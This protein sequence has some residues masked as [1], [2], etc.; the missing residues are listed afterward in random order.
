M[1]DTYL[2]EEKYRELYD[3]YLRGLGTQEFANQNEAADWVRH[4]PASCFFVSGKS[5][6]NYIA[7]KR[8]GRV[9]THFSLYSKKMELLYERY[10]ERYGSC[11][12][13]LSREAICETLVNEAAP[14]FYTSREI[15]L[16]AIQKE[17]RRRRA[18]L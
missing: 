14:C 9:R 10:M 13:D 18:R 2:R 5:L 16:R 15:T 4:Q 11:P 7:E 12:S 1:K 6:V 8:S 17:R 3:T